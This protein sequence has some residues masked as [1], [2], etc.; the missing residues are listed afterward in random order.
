[1]SD[2]KNSSLTSESTPAPTVEAATAETPETPDAAATKV[3]APEVKET[4]AESV[5]TVDTVETLMAKLQEKEA[6]LEKT[7]SKLSEWVKHSRTWEDRHDALKKEVTIQSVLEKTGLTKEFA[8]LIT[9]DKEEEMMQQAETFKNAAASLFKGSNPSDATPAAP[10]PVAPVKVT[11]NPLQ[12]LESSS[13]LVPGA[14]VI[15]E[16]SSLFQ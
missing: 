1:M 3:D 8:K 16:V 13:N 9:A 5:E 14:S 11:P 2:A 10:T 7:Q 15:D 12:A 6:E 4:N